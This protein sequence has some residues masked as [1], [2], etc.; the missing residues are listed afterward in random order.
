MSIRLR[1]WVL[2]LMML[3]ASIFLD[4]LP[5]PYNTSGLQAKAGIGESHKISKKIDVQKYL[6]MSDPKKA[7]EALL[8]DARS[9]NI[10]IDFRP[11]VPRTPSAAG[12][13]SGP[14]VPKD[15][16]QQF[17]RK[18]TKNGITEARHNSDII[19]VFQLSRQISYRELAEILSIGIRLFDTLPGYC[20]IAQVPD[21][22]VTDLV[23]LP[24]VGWV[25][26]YLPRYKYDPDAVTDEVQ[27]FEIVSLIG[28]SQTCADDFR[29][30]NVKFR[31]S[32]RNIYQALLAGPD[33]SE[34]ANLWWVKEIYLAP[35][36]STD[37][38]QKQGVT[39][40]RNAAATPSVKFK[41][42][43]SRKL[44]SATSQYVSENG[45]GY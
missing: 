7:A 34:V 6:K 17:L 24:T 43:D 13:P 4:V 25:D 21:E 44:V 36:A 10:D 37:Q 18:V 42:Q 11:E 20:Y 39:P 40:D 12:L 14:L 2:V 1:I 16:G 33:L 38:S 31:H 27:P 8:S 9:K 23:A 5:R 19:C 30:L 41:P 15:E 32:R 28:Q 45:S 35:R 26:A 22:K 29:R 3:S